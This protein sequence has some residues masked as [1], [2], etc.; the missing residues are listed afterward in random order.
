[1]RRSLPGDAIIPNPTATVMHAATISAPVK[2]VWPWLVQMGAGRAGWYSFDWVDNGGKPSATGIIPELQHIAP[3]DIMPSLPGA[4]DSFV[5][6]AVEPQRD[7]ILTVPAAGGGNLVSW[8]FFLEL[9]PSGSRL[10]VRGR[11]GAQWPAGIAGQ[12]ATPPRPIE[13]VYAFLA[14][15]PRWMMIPIAE[16]G[17]G[18]MQRRQLSG[19]KRRAEALAGKG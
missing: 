16:F 1:M 12:P 13:R 17:H 4:L 18:V 3:G 6:A 7:L 15:I 9:H 5:V 11:V 8:E 2:C 10:L 19:I 14:L